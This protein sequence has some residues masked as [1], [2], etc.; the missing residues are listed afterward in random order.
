MKKV[1]VASAIMSIFLCSCFSIGS[2]TLPSATEGY[3]PKKTYE[4]SY[5][6][7]WK[8]IQDVLL[9]ERITIITQDKANKRIQTD[10]IQGLTQAGVLGG[11]LTT[12]YKYNIMFETQGKY[13]TTI[14][15]MATLESSSKNIA[16]HDISKDNIEKVQN[17]ENYLYEKIE[18]RSNSGETK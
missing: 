13:S 14:T 18:S 16:W 6:D 1:F 11:S 4:K 7:V 8:V 9:T 3:N 10:Y 17:L 5:D 12:R 2:A 15:I